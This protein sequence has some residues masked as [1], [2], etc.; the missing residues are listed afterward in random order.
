MIYMAI[1][2]S[3]EPKLDRR[4][5]A[6][7]SRY[8]AAMQAGD[9]PTLE[10]IL[11]PGSVTRWPQSGETITGATGCVRVYQ[12]YPGGPPS[13]RL[14]R[15]SGDGFVWVAELVADYGPERWHIVSVFEFEGT[16]I[17]RVTDYFGPTVPAPEWRRE[18]VDHE[19][20][21]G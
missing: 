6:T 5:S 4:R 9:Y 8:F 13:Y 18:L 15:I 21:V 17:A 16:R 2:P 19:A 7:I 20:P 11:T 14:E 10:T 3:T 12:N 1:Q